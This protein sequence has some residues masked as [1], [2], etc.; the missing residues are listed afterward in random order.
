MSLARFVI[1]FD[2]LSNEVIPMLEN[3]EEEIKRGSVELNVK[4]KEY[5]NEVNKK[6]PKAQSL[7][8]FYNNAKYLLDLLSQIQELKGDFHIDGQYKNIPAIQNDYEIVYRYDY[9]IYICALEFSQSGW[10]KDDRWSLFIEDR[11]VFDK[12]TIKEIGEKKC[13]H[14]LK[15]VKA[16]TNIRFILHNISG[17]SRQVWTDLEYIKKE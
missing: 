4:L 15:Y 13:F 14:T 10:K 3:L 5:L 6:I 1:N 8:E 12:V 17:N 2:E 11:V 9:D 16:N 7:E